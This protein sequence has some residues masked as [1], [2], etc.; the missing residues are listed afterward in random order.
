MQMLL[1]VYAK[2]EVFVLLLTL[3]FL[4]QED[5]LVQI[6]RYQYVLDKWQMFQRFVLDVVLVF[7]LMCVPLALN[8]MEAQNVNF[9]YVL[10]N[11]PMIPPLFVLDVVL[12]LLQT[13]VLDVQLDGVDLHVNFH[14]VMES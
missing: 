13:L 5:G 12:V 2:D 9:Q 11:S 8:L 4:A 1:E 3:V 6:V 7:L 10:E 14:F